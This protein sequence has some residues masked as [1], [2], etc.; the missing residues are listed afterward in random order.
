VQHLSLLVV[1]AL[2]YVCLQDVIEV[3]NA[4]SLVEI[5]SDAVACVEETVDASRM[6]TGFFMD[7]SVSAAASARD[8]DIQLKSASAGDTEQQTG[9]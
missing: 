1:A 9:T 8:E 4:G 2:M 7:S 3:S 5:S 6:N